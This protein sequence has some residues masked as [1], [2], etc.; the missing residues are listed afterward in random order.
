MSKRDVLASP[1]VVFLGS[2]L[3]IAVLAMVLLVWHGAQARTPGKVETRIITLAKH[4]LL[5][6]GKNLRN[7]SPATSESIAEGQKTFAHYCYV[8]H[9]LDG[10]NSG[11]P[12][13][14]NMS[15]PV[16]SLASADVQSY[17]DGQLFFVINNGLWPSGMP[18]AHGILTDEE[19]WSLVSYIRHLPPAGSLG[20]PPAYN[21][22]D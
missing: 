20:D 11:V 18:A 10:Q 19:I 12:F 16:P 21:G 15:P 2:L 5:I 3:L 7:P 22:E 17:T 4:H 8:C 9:G 14:D 13:V 6:G 1:I